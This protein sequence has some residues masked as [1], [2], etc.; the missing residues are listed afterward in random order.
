MTL[1]RDSVPLLSSTQDTWRSGSCPFNPLLIILKV[2]W[3]FTA[4]IDNLHHLADISEC[5]KNNTWRH[6][7]L[8]Y[9]CIHRSFFH[10][11]F[12]LITAIH[13]SLY[14]FSTGCCVLH[15]MTIGI[16]EWDLSRSLRGTSFYCTTLPDYKR[17]QCGGKNGR[18][19]FAFIIVASRSHVSPNSHISPLLSFPFEFSQ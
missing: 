15:W 4:E 10:L 9:S 13:L 8:Y 16:S 17:G 5:G 12:P 3:M 7:I 19:A 1:D 18:S 14:Y 11:I 2:Q 6:L